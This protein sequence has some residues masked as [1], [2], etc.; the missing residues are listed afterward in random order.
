MQ[1][2]QLA[3]GRDI[4]H[5]E[6]EAIVVTQW[7]NMITHRCSVASNGRGQVIALLLSSSARAGCTVVHLT[8]HLDLPAATEV[9]RLLLKV[10]ADQPVAVI[11]DLHGVTSVAPACAAV[12]PTAWRESGGWPAVSLSLCS[13]SPPVRDRLQAEGTSR[14]VP[15][16]DDVDRAVNAAR[17]LPPY[18][19]QTTHL[20]FDLRA[21]RDART[22]ARA[23]FQQWHVEHNI[24]DALLLVSEIVS[25][26]VR[27]GEPPV[28]LTLRLRD[29][30][31]RIAVHDAGASRRFRH[32]RSVTSEDVV[33]GVLLPEG[34]LGLSL[35]GA[36]STTWGVSNVSAGPGKTVWCELRV[37]SAEGE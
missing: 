2:L 17:A 24:D 27:H 32:L 9:R 3:P 6:H 31:L 33:N 22:C 28:R 36:V 34:G 11:G 5:A 19:S 18:V 23:T 20:R 1:A 16:H 10:M 14:F 29:G 7:H 26:C 25:N 30:L 8:G 13:P 21:P 4:A 37:A 35:V 12:F 15:L